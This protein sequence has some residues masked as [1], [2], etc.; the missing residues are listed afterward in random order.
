MFPWSGICC[1][2]QGAGGYLPAQVLQCPCM[3]LLSINL[4]RAFLDLLMLS[5]STPHCGRE[6]QKV[7]AL[8]VRDDFL[9]SALNGPPAG[10]IGFSDLRLVVL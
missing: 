9:K 4:S 7:T 1:H 6:V 3:N 2:I 5:G 8:S 10:F